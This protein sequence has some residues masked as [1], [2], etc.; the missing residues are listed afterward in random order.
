M[1][2][3]SQTQYPI[4]PVAEAITGI[5]AVNSNPV[6]L[7]SA[8]VTEIIETGA[9]LIQA[10]EISENL[11]EILPVTDLIQT[12]QITEPVQEIIG[13]SNEDNQN[14]NQ[15]ITGTVIDTVDGIIDEVLDVV[16][17]LPL[18]P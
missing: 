4:L 8:A 3:G 17:D 14:N 12:D 9:A 1:N 10:D 2:T 15:T 16:P 7:V 6:Q 5:D 11:D 13:A 18:W